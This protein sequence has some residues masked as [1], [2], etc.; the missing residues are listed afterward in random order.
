MFLPAQEMPNKKVIA[1]ITYSQCGKTQ[2]NNPYSIVP[3]H[4]LLHI[5]PSN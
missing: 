5:F 1:K 3:F 4:N 2:Y